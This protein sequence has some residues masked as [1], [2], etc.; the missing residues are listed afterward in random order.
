M[1]THKQEKMEVHLSLSIN[2][3]MYTK[4]QLQNNF[5]YEVEKTKEDL[6]QQL[7]LHTIKLADTNDS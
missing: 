6:T 1:N 2:K 3:L 7:V 4:M 5:K